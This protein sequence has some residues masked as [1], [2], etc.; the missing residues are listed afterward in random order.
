MRSEGATPSAKDAAVPL[1]GPVLFSDDFNSP[2]TFAENWRPQGIG[3]IAPADG[4]LS[5]EGGARLQ[6]SRET[7]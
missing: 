1:R 5:F 7:P 6:M 2:A 4:A 3:R